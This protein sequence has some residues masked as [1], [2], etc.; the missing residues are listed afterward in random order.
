MLAA[1]IPTVGPCRCTRK[2][3]VV[4]RF[5][6][7]SILKNR[8]ARY[9]SLSLLRSS[10][11]SHGFFHALSPHDIVLTANSRLSLYLHNAYDRFQHQEGKTAWSTPQILPL[12]NWLQQQ[13]YKLNS[14]GQILLDTFQEQCLWQQVIE[15]SK[16]AS[17]VMHPAQLAE[18]VQDS[19]NL[20]TQWQVTLDELSSFQHQPEIACLLKWFSLFQKK[21][22]QKN[23]ITASEL[24]NLLYEKK[25]SVERK[26]ILMG[27]DDF[28]PTLE[29]LWSQIKN[30]E[31][32]NLATPSHTSKIILEDT[33]SE[34]HT[35]A[36]WIK[37][38]WQENSAGKFCCVVPELEK[39]R[40]QVERIFIEEF[41]D[42]KNF[43]ISAG[44]SLSQNPAVHTALTL[45]QWLTKP[46]TIQQIAPLLQSSYLCHDETES[47]AGAQ[48]DVLLREQNYLHVTLSDALSV[49]PLLKSA[50]HFAS[51]FRLLLQFSQEKK[52]IKQK[53]SE[54]A[55][56]FLGLL[57]NCHWPGE[58]TQTTEE[59]QA[60]EKFKKSLSAFSQLEFLFE[61]ISLSHAIHLLN[62][63]IQKT[64]FQVKSHNEPIQIMGALESSSI[65]F[66]ALWVM[67]LHDGTWPSPSKP[68]SL[69][70]YSLQQKYNMPHATAA[71]EL[72]FCTRMTERLKHSAKEVIF[73][74]PTKEN[75]QQLFPS[76]LIFD[77]SPIKYDELQLQDE[78]NQAQK[79]FLNKQLETIEDSH[80][81]PVKNF[82][83]IR[84][85]S[86]ILKLQALC[87]Y[88]AFA[89][90]RLQAKAF[91][92]PILG[93][94]AVTKGI[95]IHHILFLLWQ[96]LKDQETLLALSEEILDT[97]I[98][99]YIDET[100]ETQLPHTTDENKNLFYRVE[101]KR[102]FVLI[103]NWLALE[104]TRPAFS[105]KAL[106]TECEILIESLPLKLRLDRV[107]ELSD[108][109][110]LL[111]DYKSGKTKIETLLQ[112]RLTNPQ[113][114]LYAAFQ[115][116]NEKEFSAVAFAEINNYKMSLQGISKEEKNIAAGVESIADI[117]NK[118]QINRW[119]ML[120]QNWQQSLTALAKDFCEGKKCLNPL[121]RNTCQQCG[122]QSVCRVKLI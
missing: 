77:I 51:R 122:L 6:K 33:E 108:G 41:G 55:H 79:I 121:D 115:N 9:S 19:W 83:T 101:K 72:Q 113:L 1:P 5:Q 120:M 117:K 69:I 4:T 26:I 95:L 64:I 13:F 54:W 111:I 104:K 23:Y 42:N 109:S 81:Y 80:L 99:R 106:E 22:L 78:K 89:K 94:P 100:F 92:T 2:H 18:L 90:I 27:F 3:T 10:K 60:L 74:S 93:I 118:L 119:E 17:N 35:M 97:L 68:H 112:E 84:G 107:D 91:N 36:R 14:E 7:K 38:Q 24:P 47:C 50:H 86:H 52:M 62:S 46:L 114:P 49:I 116:K 44:T 32:H 34:L 11:L 63:L 20:I 67:G 65:I 12:Q 88:Q 75:D 37:K 87:G 98:L 53:P 71:R 43:N 25:L 8:I 59:F 29:K 58:H 15:E 82:N 40:T 103:K 48:I 30:I 76:K 57:K 96:Y 70:P 110:L 31:I 66:D 21:L 16:L 102:L 85:G 28:N 73:S 61:K 39:I 45:L 105:V 56:H